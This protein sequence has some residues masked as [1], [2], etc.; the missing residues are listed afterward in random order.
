MNDHVQS[1]AR[2]ASVIAGAT[3]LSRV[4]GFVRDVIIAFA[5]GAGPLADAF[6]VAFRIPNV[7]RRL[8]AEGSLT[9]AFVPVFTRIRQDQGDQAAFALARSTLVW[10]LLILGMIVFIVLI[11]ARPL[12][13]VIAPGFLKDPEVFSQTVTLVRIC[14]PYILF[15]SGVALCM[16]ILNSM[17]HFLGP[18]LAPCVL[19]SVLIL[20]ALL[21]VWSGISVPL[22]LSIGVLLAGLGQWLLQ[23]PFLRQQGF[24]WRGEWSLSDQGVMRMGRLLLPTVLG[25]AVYQLNIVLNTVLASFLPR[26]SIS[27]LYY[28]DRLVQFPL[29]VF[30]VAL[31]T[32]AL[33]SLASLVAQ[34]RNEEF[35]E[36]L[37]AT[38]RLILFISLPAMAGLIGLSMP[39]VEVLFVRGAFDAQA[40]QATAWAL[41]GYGIGLPAFSMVRSLV[42]AYYALEDTRTPVVVASGCLVLNLCLGLVLMQFIG[43]VGLALAV[44]AASWANIVLLGSLLRHKLGAWLETSCNPVIML[45]LSVLMGVGCS[46]TASFGW[47]ALLGIPLWAAGYVLMARLLGLREAQT[48]IQ[49]VNRRLKRA[50]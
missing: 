24:L 28:A 19:N 38:L 14:F 34:G 33:P 20:C 32:A 23:Q 7:L 41:V 6:F 44:S 26:G 10:L 50:S 16:G 37:N 46:L 13:M 45:G 21:G 47:P 12:T 42:S 31:S 2:N 1:I 25:A 18:A 3:L 27:F 29:G 8:F 4:L 39:L 9:M 30:G 17:G 36:T 49:V 40:A 11:G 22:A 48:F 15:I 5:L 43:H 35:A